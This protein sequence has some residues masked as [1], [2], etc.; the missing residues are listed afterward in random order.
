MYTPGGD[1]N[2]GLYAPFGP[3]EMEADGIYQE[4]INSTGTDNMSSYQT[5]QVTRT[6]T[7]TFNAGEWVYQLTDAEGETYWLQSYS[8]QLY[9]WNATLLQDVP[10]TRALLT[11]LPAGWSY[12]AFVLPETVQ[13]IANGTAVVLS[14]QYINNYQRTNEPWAM[15]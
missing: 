4:A 1:T 8:Q 3:I 11:E 7:Y 10:A 15:Q 14:D 13:Q 2:P 9:P 12:D 5:S 6:T